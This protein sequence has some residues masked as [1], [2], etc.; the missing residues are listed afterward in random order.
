MPI[1]EHDERRVRCRRL[2]H[3]VAF[4]YCR[5][6][7]GCTPCPS[8][9]DC[10]W[11]SFDVR[12]FLKENLPAQELAALAERRPRAKVVTLLDLI[13][14]ARRRTHGKGEVDERDT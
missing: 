11:E 4:R 9:M 6:Q 1:G 13:E 10:W 2:G 12:A 5:T 14:Q 8:I 7:E 3:E